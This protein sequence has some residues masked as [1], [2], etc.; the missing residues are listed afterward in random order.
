MLAYGLSFRPPA[1]SRLARAPSEVA[2]EAVVAM[3]GAD[4]ETDVVTLVRIDETGMPIGT[5]RL[6]LSARAMTRVAGRL[7]L[8]V[9]GGVAFIRER[10]PSDGA[11]RAFELDRFVERP[12]PATVRAAARWN[13]EALVVALDAAGGLTV[14]RFDGVESVD[15]PVGAAPLELSEAA[16]AEQNG[17]EPLLV[18]R[19]DRELFTARVGKDGVRWTGRTALRDRGRGLVIESRPDQTRRIWTSVDLDHGRRRLVVAS[20]NDDDT[21]EAADWSFE[22]PEGTAAVPLGVVHEKDETLVL[23]GTA[24]PMR[25]IKASDET[26]QP[27]PIFFAAWSSGWLRFER[28]LLAT[29]VLLVVVGLFAGRRT[30]AKATRAAGGAGDASEL[31]PAP[32]SLARRVL[33]L[34]FDVTLAGL[35]SLGVWFVWALGPVEVAYLTQFGDTST[36]LRSDRSDPIQVALSADGQLLVWILL[37]SFAATSEALTGRSLGKAMLGLRV[38]T[39]DGSPPGVAASATRAAL[40]FVDAVTSLGFVGLTLAIFTRRRQRLGDILAG[41]MVVDAAPGAAAR[42]SRAPRPPA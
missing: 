20:L 41:T 2:G 40:L 11:G 18:A 34:L 33:A 24:G 13:D 30:P 14:E 10:R 8:F 3:I 27:P 22:L 26:Q 9:D 17:E 6:E 7:V 1:V 28:P 38:V 19:N 15:V 29:M 32:A 37:F 31:G 4:G 42:S 25:A 21:L 23:W 35:V 12:G 16:L 5:S 39:I 36:W